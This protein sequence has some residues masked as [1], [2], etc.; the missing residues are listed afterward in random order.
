[1]EP[2]YDECAVVTS[3]KQTS[4]VDV[5]VVGGGAI[6]LSV[7][8]RA[9]Q[10]GMSVAVLERERPGAGASHV[11]AGMLAPVTE[12][13]FGPS[14]E[15]ALRLG[16]AA[17]AGWPAFA[18]E[19]E[20]AS[21]HALG[22]R[23]TGT[24]MVARDRDEA[25]GL[26]R[27]IG[28]RESLGLRV[29]RLRG[30]AARE[31]E[32]ALAPGLRLA[33]EAPDDHCVDPRRVSSALAEAAQ[34]AGAELIAPC[35]VDRLV[36]DR[37]TKRASGVQS[38]DGT[39]VNAGTIVLAA[40]A[41]SGLLA[42]PAAAAAIPVRPVKG[43][44]LRLRDPTGPGLL[45]RVVRY[46]R[47]YLVP[48]GDGRYVLGATMEERGFDTTP[49]AGAVLDLL[50]EAREVVPGVTELELEEVGVG[51]RPGSPDNL[52]LVGHS[53]VPG[54]VWASGHHRNGILLAALTGE[55]VADLLAGEAPSDLARICD[56]ARLVTPGAGEGAGNASAPTGAA[57]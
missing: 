21:G 53:P 17:A 15:R 54:L 19:L 29:G 4:A 50:R 55:M 44:I 49:T 20:Q 22:L 2:D 51:L 40:G 31:L 45:D 39:R 11:A 37:G 10:R 32:P 6:G 33:L 18:E 8:W 23:A 48:R 28:F 5:A 27:E 3:I 41:W 46:E 35:A 26:E 9:A 13:E 57:A 56:P 42:G 7:A 52:P 12:V 36:F 43:Q 1:M 25:E 24:L 14:G 47:G 34:R 16:L 38:R 30:S